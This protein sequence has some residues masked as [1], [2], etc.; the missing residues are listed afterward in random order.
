MKNPPGTQSTQRPWWL[1]LGLAAMGVVWIHGASGIASTTHYIGLG[2]EAMVYAVGGGL[3][4]LGLLLIVQALRGRF[5]LIAPEDEDEQKA[6]PEPETTEISPSPSPRQ[7]LLLALSGVMLPLLT[8]RWLGFPLTAMLVFA[9]LTRAFASRRP[10]LDLLV[11]A[12]L[13]SLAWWVFS[14]LGIALGAF[15]PVWKSL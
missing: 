13:G 4:V 14:R 12:L 9:L 1:G 7:A 10:L 11:G 5:T 6:L 8:M 15:L 2:P 3:T